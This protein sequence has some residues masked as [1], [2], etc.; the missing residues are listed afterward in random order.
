MPLTIQNTR[1]HTPQGFEPSPKGQSTLQALYNETTDT[2]TVGGVLKTARGTM[3]LVEKVA[4][5]VSAMSNAI[6]GISFAADTFKILESVSHIKTLTDQ[7]KREI[8]KDP[9]KAKAEK[10]DRNLQIASASMGL[11]I[12]T[13]TGMKLLDSV[14]AINLAKIT[15]AMGRVPVIGQAARF[16]PFASV[17][18]G[19]EI[20]KASLS[21][22]ISAEKLKQN[23]AQLKHVEDKQNLWSGKITK[24][25]ATGKIERIE[26]KMQKFKENAENLKKKAEESEKEVENHK[27]AYTAIHKEKFAAQK[28]AKLSK[29]RAFKKRVSDLE[30]EGNKL[31]KKINKAASCQNEF[32]D[33]LK[34]SIDGYDK[35]EK[36]R[37]A[38][39]SIKAR[40]SQ[41]DL[42]E[43]EKSELDQLCAEKVA[44]WDIKK[45]NLKSDRV[46]E[47]L[48]I[49]LNTLFIIYSIAS[50][51]LAATGIGLLPVMIAMASVC[52]V[53]SASSIS[54]SLYKKYKKNKPT[55]SVEIPYFKPLMSCQKTII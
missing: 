28:E 30:K 38:W 41:E 11:A 46:K 12:S 45:I 14:G 6:K 49:A 2:S 33:Q 47:S 18:A 20:A 8:S 7:S 55:H 52:L 25:F 40:L 26:A 44:K 5:P 48:G 29:S 22:A 9:I 16:V 42:T 21:I 15:E 54:L 3:Q 43:A 27:K 36:K 31:I 34:E 37:D 13:M 17:L 19:F 23:K 4:S 53:V 51:I 32:C 50:I 35:L 1:V 10:K 39:E 24:D